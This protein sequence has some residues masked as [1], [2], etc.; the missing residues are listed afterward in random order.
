MKRRGV[1][2]WSAVG[3]STLFSA[4]WAFWGSIEAFHEG[5]IAREWTANLA[6]AVAYLIP[7][8]AIMASALASIL[9]PRFGPALHLAVAAV[10]VW[11]FE[12]YD[13]PAVLAT[14][15][16]PLCVVCGLYFYGITEPRKWA[17]RAL[18]G[19]PIATAIVSGAYPAWLAVTR[20]DDG[21]YNLRII[22]GNGVR[23]AWAPHGPG[24]AEHVAS[25][26]EAQ[27]TCERLSRDGLRLESVPPR[28]WRLPTVEEAVCSAVRRGQNAGGTW[29]A[30]S[31][32]PH[33]RVPP[34]KETPLWSRY[35]PAMYRWTATGADAR[36]AYRVVW[37]GFANPL[38]KTVR[39]HFRCV[40]DPAV[41]SDR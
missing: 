14:L 27:D 7:M 6:G 34:N 24:W 22:Q 10:A 20:Q 21:N 28:V 8:L 26:S 41:V 4:F 38:P 29:D 16:V 1:A 17:L 33:Y 35:S 31:M 39:I 25:W 32:R 9:W 30:R 12:L 2:G 13:R 11:R 19:I 23:L 18:V 3:I 37:N 15:A 40:A 5:W 36:R